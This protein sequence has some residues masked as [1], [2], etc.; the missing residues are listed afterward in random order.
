MLLEVVSEGL[1]VFLW[2]LFGELLGYELVDLV[3]LVYLFGD[4]LYEGWGRFD[5]VELLAVVWE[6]SLFFLCKG[7]VL[8][9]GVVLLSSHL[10]YA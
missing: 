6:S 10:F 7:K 4:V 8:F 9:L 5:V 3:T 2:G 1:A